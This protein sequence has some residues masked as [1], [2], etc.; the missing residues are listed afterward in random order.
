MKDQ[1]YIRSHGYLL[2]YCHKTLQYL[3]I[4]HYGI[5]GDSLNNVMAICEDITSKLGNMED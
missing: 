5:P 2:R 4:L 3:N 1:E